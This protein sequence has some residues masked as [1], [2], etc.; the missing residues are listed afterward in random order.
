MLSG[1]PETILLEV[2]CGEALNTGCI[3]LRATDCIRI[4]AS[5]D[6]AI[7]IETAEMS[8]LV[9]KLPVCGVEHSFE[10][11]RILPL[12]SSVEEQRML[13]LADISHQSILQGRSR[14][15]QIRSATARPEGAAEVQATN[16]PA[17]KIRSCLVRFHFPQ[18]I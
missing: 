13:L 2:K 17:L 7:I 3:L 10:I 4:F 11:T 6:V 14:S 16:R 15:T 5:L 8:A 18:R 1:D 12:L 9:L